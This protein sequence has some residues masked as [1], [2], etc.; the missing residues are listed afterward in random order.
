MTTQTKIFQ[1][2]NTILHVT[3][4]DELTWITGPDGSR[5]YSWVHIGPST[6]ADDIHI[7]TVIFWRFSL[8]FG[9][10]RQPISYKLKHETDTLPLPAR[11]I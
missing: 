4:L 7:F 10:T 5:N 1:I 8:I 9:R 3:L 11:S 2:G 6:S